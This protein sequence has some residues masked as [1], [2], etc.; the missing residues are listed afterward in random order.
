M[1]LPAVKFVYIWLDP[2]L[3]K[4]IYDRVNDHE[5]LHSDAV[6]PRLTLRKYS[7]KKSKNNNV[8]MVHDHKK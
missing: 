4:T 2:P 5:I 1:L 7:H 8:V 6:S 3:K